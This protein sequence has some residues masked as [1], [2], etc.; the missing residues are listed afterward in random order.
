[1]AGAGSRLAVALS[2]Y[3]IYIASA[4]RIV[5]KL[6]LNRSSSMKTGDDRQGWREGDGKTCRW[7]QTGG[8]DP[9]GS[10]EPW[11]DYLCNTSP[12]RGN[13]GFCDCN[14]NT[15]FD[16]NETGFDC[17]GA[18]GTDATCEIICGLPPWPK[19]KCCKGDSVK[20]TACRAGASIDRWCEGIPD[21]DGCPATTT[22]TTTTTTTMAPVTG[23]C[24]FR[25][26]G[27][28]SPRGRRQAWFDRSCRLSLSRGDS[29]FCDC[30][31]NNV[32]D[33]NET[34]FD[35]KGPGS[36][37]CNE[38]CQIDPGECCTGDS[39]KCIA[40]R[41]GVPIQGLCRLNPALDGCEDVRQP[42][43]DVRRRRSR[44]RDPYDY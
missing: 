2:V 23:S 8:C 1:M 38:I 32:F 16:A 43:V 36:G 26:T 37:N 21:F 35:C 9:R 29:G 10:R 19:K 22:T 42:P 7:R 25:R 4:F 18:G 11:N 28:C 6:D 17:R 3:T 12:S 34:G 33:A 14:G 44:R 5:K 27:G 24:M 39:A 31:G 13:S 30:N 20:C 41:A 15:V 40:C